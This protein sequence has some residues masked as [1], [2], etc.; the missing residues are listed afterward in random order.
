MRTKSEPDLQSRVSSC[1]PFSIGRDSFQAIRTL[2][3]CFA[4]CV[5]LVAGPSSASGQDDPEP[6][7]FPDVI[8]C[9][10]ANEGLDR[11]YRSWMQAHCV[12]VAMQICGNIAD[13]SEACF[14]THVATM[15]SYYEQ[16]MPLIPSEITALPLLARSYQRRVNRVREAFTVAPDCRDLSGFEHLQCEA[17]VLGVAL[18]DLFPLARRA[19]VDLP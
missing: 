18:I 2:F 13:G 9:M 17:L 7:V 10:L 5:A 19:N 15:R 6:L 14:Q 12:N 11:R 8:S 16:L 3:Y 4:I 1:L